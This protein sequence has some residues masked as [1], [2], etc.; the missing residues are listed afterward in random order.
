MSPQDLDLDAIR[1][2][3]GVDL[4]VWPPRYDAAYQP[5]LGA[6]HWLPEVECAPPAIRDR[7]ILADRS[8]ET[9]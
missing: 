8:G 1:R 9:E 5:P 6:E 2:D 7:L 4:A 3:R